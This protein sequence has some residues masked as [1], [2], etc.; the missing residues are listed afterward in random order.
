VTK[1]C[2]HFEKVNAR[3]SYNRAT[4]DLRSRK[5][6][7]PAGFWDGPLR[8]KIDGRTY[9]A[10]H[11]CWLLATG[12]WPDCD[13]SF[14]N[15]NCRDLQFDNLSLT[16]AKERARKRDRNSKGYVKHGRRFR[17][18]VGSKRETLITTWDEW[19]AKYWVRHL[20]EPPPRIF[21]VFKGGVK[22]DL[23]PIGY[24]SEEWTPE[25]ALVRAR[26]HAAAL[27][28]VDYGLFGVDP[29]LPASEPGR[30]GDFD[31]YRPE[32]LARL[33]LKELELF[34]EERQKQLLALQA[35]LDAFYALQDDADDL[36]VMI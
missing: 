11:I 1:H 29:R 6:G 10:S 34:H 16:T 13:V 28:G 27:G 15:G 32:A 3:I 26:A 21:K 12:D 19:D 14:K 18:Q 17:V 25:K 20:R 31:R 7:E 5:T 35:A 2:P 4:G 36:E 23:G 30:A 22:L 33:G 24:G 8:I 9:M